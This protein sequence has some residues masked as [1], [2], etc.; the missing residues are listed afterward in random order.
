MRNLETYITENR[1]SFDEEPNSGHFKRFQ[2][3]TN[4]K[5]NLKIVKWSISIAASICILVS[6]GIMLYQYDSHGNNNIAMSSCE[7]AID[8]RACYLNKMMALAEKIE[9]LTQDFDR[10]DRA[11]VMMA[12]QTIIDAT[13]NSFLAS[14]LPNELP[15][16]RTRTI[17]SDYYQRNLQGLELIAQV[18]Q[19]HHQ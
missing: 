8:I 13:A 2:Q 5:R 1:N 14:D 12:V 4:R 17:L 19:T 9:T 15:E 11:E 10:W 16:E 7:N 6:A 18:V 3:K